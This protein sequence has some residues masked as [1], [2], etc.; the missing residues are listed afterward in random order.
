[1]TSAAARRHAMQLRAQADAILIGAA[2]MR[3]DDP[4]LTLRGMRGARQP[5]RNRC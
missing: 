4:R 1:M 3:E 2:T 5:W